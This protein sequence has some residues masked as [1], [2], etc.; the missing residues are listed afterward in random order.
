MIFHCFT[1]LVSHFRPNLKV[2]QS[3]KSVAKR[4]PHPRK[5]LLSAAAMS[6]YDWEKEKFSDKE[7]VKYFQDIDF[8]SKLKLETLTCEAC[9]L[10]LKY[11]KIIIFS[12]HI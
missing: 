5:F 6:S 1:K 2:V 10:R 8:C 11:V 12:H 3:V 7:L 4:F 9:G